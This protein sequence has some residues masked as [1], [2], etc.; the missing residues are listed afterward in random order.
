MTVFEKA[1][2]NNTYQISLAYK[3]ITAQ[4]LN[5]ILIP[6]IVN[7]YI[8]SDNV[9]GQSGLTE[10]IFILAITNSFFPPLVRLID[11]YYIFVYL[12]YNYYNR[13]RMS[14]YI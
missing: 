9:Y 12:K 5:S 7:I 11:P 1:Y 6:I 8:K 4:L 2:T 3:S 13:P 14:S 10:D